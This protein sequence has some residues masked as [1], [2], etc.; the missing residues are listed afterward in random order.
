MGFFTWTLANKKI[1]LLKSG[2]FARSCQLKYDG[3]GA[4]L[5]PDGTLVKES[6]YEGYGRFGGIDVY[7]LAADWNKDAIPDLLKSEAFMDAATWGPKCPYKDKVVQ[8]ALVEYAKNGADAMF[9]VLDTLPKDHAGRIWFNENE[10]KRSIGI[11]LCCGETNPMVPFPI[12]IVDY[13]RNATPETYEYLPP[14][15]STQ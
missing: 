5:K 10:Y 11:M 3:Y 9:A 15:V 2:D 4:I 13:K 12:K 1:K 14:S 8:D 7:D 6:C